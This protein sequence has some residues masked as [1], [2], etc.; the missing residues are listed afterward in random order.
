[1]VVFRVNTPLYNL[2]YEGERMLRELDR[3]FFN[4]L[5]KEVERVEKKEEK[6]KEEKKKEKKVVEKKDKDEY[7]G[8]KVSDEVHD[9]LLGLSEIQYQALVDERDE[10]YVRATNAMDYILK[11][12]E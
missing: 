11:G 5:R 12:L 10:D 9:I 7:K 1:M 2:L 8:I 6:K 4:T 3:E